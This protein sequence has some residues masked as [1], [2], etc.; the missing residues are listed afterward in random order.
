M[1]EVAFEMNPKSS[2]D[3][4]TGRDVVCMWADKKDTAQRPKDRVCEH[5]L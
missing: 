4:Y 5:V 2:Y 1:E 3:I